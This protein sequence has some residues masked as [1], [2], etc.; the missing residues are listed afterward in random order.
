MPQSNAAHELLEGFLGDPSA[1]D[2]PVNV[3]Q[4]LLERIPN[5]E[6]ERTNQK[7]SFI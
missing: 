2:F 1:E 4:E 6:R 5:N 3:V 7:R